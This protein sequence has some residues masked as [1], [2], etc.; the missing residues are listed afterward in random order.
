MFSAG[1]V[2]V[3]VSIAGALLSLAVCA[4]AQS[5]PT[6]P[7]RVVTTAPGSANDVVARLVAP[8]VSAALGEQLVI[9]N[10]G[11][12]AG[13]IVSH[14]IPDGYT[15]L[16]YGSPLWIGPLLRPAPYDPAID[17]A[18]ITFTATSPNVLVV[19]PSVPVNSVKDLIALAKAKPGQLNY[20]SSSI[21]ATPHLAAELFKAMTGVNIVRVPY[22]GSGGALVALIA[23][24]V[25]LMFPNVGAVAPYLKSPKLK[26]LAVSTKQPSALAPGLP[27]LASAGVPGYESSSPLAVFAPAKT[28][29]A[30]IS[31]LNREMIRVLE[32]A[33]IRDRLFKAGMEP[34]S[35]SPAETAAIVKAEIAKW[36]KLVNDTGMRGSL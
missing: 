29:V 3:T 36:G 21:G 11:I 22:K 30:I 6:K 2:L 13:D 18:P 5:Y 1:R 27:T 34:M 8:K 7:I 28:P 33:E 24:E 9:D 25:Q 12:L 26:A 10:R 31:K 4:Y 32:S 19:H 15:I 17:F 23:G 16:F 20:G 14:A 35:T